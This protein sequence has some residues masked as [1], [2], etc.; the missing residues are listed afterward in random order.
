M[1]DMLSILYTEL[2]KN[3][4]ISTEVTATR[5]AYY[6]YGEERDQTKPFIILIPLDPPNSGVSGSNQE[7]NVRHTY[8]IDVQGSDRRKV[9]EIAKAVKLVMFTLGYGQLPEGLD[10]WFEETKRF[11]DARRYRG[12]TKLYDNNY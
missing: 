3:P 7:L 10:E 2:L 1:K 4:V 6:D 8:Q 5:I 11:V 12:F 9:K